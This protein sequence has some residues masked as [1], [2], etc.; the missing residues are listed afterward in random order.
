MFPGN[1]RIIAFVLFSFVVS[2]YFLNEGR[3]GSPAYK[4][5][6]RNGS[7]TP[8]IADSPSQGVPSKKVGCYA[9]MSVP[10]HVTKEP[11]FLA[12][13]YLWLFVFFRVCIEYTCTLYIV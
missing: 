11:E 10:G 12:G 8:S 9:G 2:A 3:G 1:V 13:I 6:C 4:K 5:V 7:A